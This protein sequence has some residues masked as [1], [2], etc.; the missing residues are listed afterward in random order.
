MNLVIGLSDI[1]EN[2]QVVKN[3]V[4]VVLQVVLDTLS[5]RLIQTVVIVKMLFKDNLA[6]HCY[7][8]RCHVF[9]CSHALEAASDH[10]RH[11][12]V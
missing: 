10:E 9:G 7:L 5:N 6:L 11:L 2:L 12:M 3:C 8:V 1:L 4:I